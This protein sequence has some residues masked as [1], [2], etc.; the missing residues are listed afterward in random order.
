MS[1][2]DWEGKPKTRY[3]ETTRTSG[4]DYYQVEEMDIWLEKLKAYY[5]L[6]EKQAETLMFLFGDEGVK[7]ENL[8]KLQI[9]RTKAEEYDAL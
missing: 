6:I 5:E 8:M 2:S 4:F 1:V 7:T 3:E 9:W